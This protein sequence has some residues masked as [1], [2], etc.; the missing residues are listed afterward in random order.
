MYPKRNRN[1]LALILI[2]LAGG[3][4]GCTHKLEV[5][6]QPPEDLI[7]RD[8]MVSIFVDLRLMD[9]VLNFEQ[10]R[11]SR[12]VDDKKYYLYL[13]VMDKYCITRE[14]FERSF[15]YYQEDLDQIDQIYADAITRLSLMKSKEE[16]EAEEND[17]SEENEPQED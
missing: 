10:L 13:S 12:H 15:S 9:A 6:E 17:Q 16:Q 5:E 3:I 1:T 2:L 8:T 11:G 4:I 7:P 14:Q